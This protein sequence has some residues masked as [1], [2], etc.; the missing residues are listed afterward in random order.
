MSGTGGGNPNTL[1][2]YSD[3][4]PTADGTPMQGGAIISDDSQYRYLLMRQWDMTK[5][6]MTFVMLNPS[7][8]DATREDATTRSCIAIARQNGC[9][10]ILLVNLFAVRSKDPSQVITFKEPIGGKKANEYLRFAAGRAEK[11]VLAWGN[12][13]P[14]INQQRIFDVLRLLANWQGQFYTLGMTA[15]GEPTHPRFVQQTTPLIPFNVQA[16]LNSKGRA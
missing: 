2:D 9:G 13:G 3:D 12:N 1:P 10:A 14:T 11:I 8:A 5:P 4:N 15:Q 16:Y 6:T 7:T